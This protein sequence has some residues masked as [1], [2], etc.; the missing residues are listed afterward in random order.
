MVVRLALQVAMALAIGLP[1]CAAQSRTTA[2]RTSVMDFAR[3]MRWGQ[4]EKA[5]ELVP[6]ARRLQ[7]VAQKRAAQSSMTIHEY[8]IRSVDPDATGERAV[9]V[10]A[11]AWS[12]PNDPVMRTDLLAQDWRWQAVGW[13]MV[14][15]KAMQTPEITSPEQ[16]L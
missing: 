7:F 8:D 3:H 16:G 6:A 13:Q 14:E 2:L 5:A 15:Q 4:V 9:V 10:V 12:R 11:V 1:G